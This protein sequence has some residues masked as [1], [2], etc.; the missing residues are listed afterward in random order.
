MP[1][2]A[3]RH[4]LGSRSTISQEDNAMRSSAAIM[5]ALLETFVLMSPARADVSVTFVNSYYYPALQQDKR[6]AVLDDLRKTLEELG[7]RLTSGEDLKIEIFS[8]MPMDVATS[9]DGTKS[10]QMDIQYTLRQNGKTVL[11]DRE[12]I[13]DINF[14]D[15]P[16]VPEPKG[17]GGEHGSKKDPLAPEKAM[18]RDWFTQRF[19]AYIA[20][21]TK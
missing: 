20:P 13:S 3:S 6:Q 9:K 14:V 1:E 8:Y 18:L 12:T 10:T 4:G 2:D 21:T 17:E 5:I 11:H 19:A 7:A 15:K 16:V